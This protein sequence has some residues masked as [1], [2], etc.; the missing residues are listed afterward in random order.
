MRSR[1]LPLF[2]VALPVALVVAAMAREAGRAQSVSPMDVVMGIGLPGVDRGI[3]A[4]EVRGA[5][6]AIRRPALESRSVRHP[7]DAEG[8]PVIAGKVIVKFRDGLTDS[9]R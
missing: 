4:D 7:I 3:I 6:R 1:R 9:D 8:A 5:G 2:W